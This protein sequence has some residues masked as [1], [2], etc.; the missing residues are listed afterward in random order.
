M[1]MVDSTLTSPVSGLAGPAE[2][3]ARR[4]AIRAAWRTLAGGVPAPGAWPATPVLRLGERRFSGGV[5]RRL[6]VGTPPLG[7]RLLLP[8]GDAPRPVL[9]TQVSH[10]AWAAAALRRGWAACVV[11]ACD[12]RDD[13]EA[14]ATAFGD[15]CDGGRIAWRAWALSRALDVLEAERDVD[16]RRV[17][18]AGHSRNGKA[19]LLAA[20]FDERFTAVVSSSSG[21][22]GA[23][24]ARLCRE[25]HF[26]EGIE[27]LTRH[28]PRWYHP[29]L[30]EWAGR[31]E[32]LPT[33]AH[34]L[35][36]L[37]APTPV[38]VSVAVHDP[39]ESTWAA[40]A[41]VA[42]ARPTYALHGVP[43][44]LELRYRGGGHELSSAGV[45]AMLD[46]ITGDRGRPS[47]ALH[48]GDGGPFVAT[49]P[50]ARPLLRGVAL[51]RALGAALGDAPPRASAGAVPHA[52]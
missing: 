33:D 28:Y 48:P 26:G 39:V 52:R 50:A 21:V 20:A 4:E 25:R 29:R 5:E 27:L 40:E 46:W 22:L 16:G 11:A 43:E 35:L 32:E 47:A 42:A 44:A 34:E 37:A 24:P 18:V 49:A 30:R 9:L 13:T 41:S 19:A 38:L 15:A 12:A 36:A 14:I 45:E 1:P 23:I 8:D 31:E 3:P 17:V 7:L 6:A 51:A 2:W 10:P